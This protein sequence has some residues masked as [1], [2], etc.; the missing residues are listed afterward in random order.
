MIYAMSDIHG[1]YEAYCALLEKI[2]F[3]D[4]DT[5]YI[6][7]DAIDRGE[8]YRGK[9]FQKNRH[10]ALDCGCVYGMALGVYCLDTGEVWYEEM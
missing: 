4:E 9:I 1:C 7:G 5:L 8:E 2:Q 10:I 3:S 6:V